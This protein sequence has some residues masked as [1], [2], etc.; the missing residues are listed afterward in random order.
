MMTPDPQPH[1]TTDNDPPAAILRF[2]QQI[3]DAA[4]PGTAPELGYAARVLVP[5]LGCTRHTLLPFLTKTLS[6]PHLL[7]ILDTQMALQGR[8]IIEPYTL[9][10]P[11]AKGTIVDVQVCPRDI[12][13]PDDTQVIMATLHLSPA[14][15]KQQRAVTAERDRLRSLF[16]RLPAFVAL[17][18]PDHSL[19]YVNQA[20]RE[21]FGEPG[22]TPCYSIIKGKN[23]PCS[24][25]APFDTFDTGSLSICEW[26]SPTLGRCFRI[27]SY[28]FVDDDNAS[29]VLKLG[30]D[31]TQSKQ[32]Q[33]ALALS[34]ARYR[35]ITDNL[36]VGIAV[37]GEDMQMTAANPL[38]AEW[39]GVP[40][41]FGPPDETAL[42]QFRNL[43]RNARRG[44]EHDDTENP[45]DNDP[46]TPARKTFADGKVHE[47]EYS[48]RLDGTER[49]FRITACPI[50][51]ASDK[52]GSVILLLEDVTERKRVMERL[53]RARRLEAMGTLAAG[54]AHEINQPLSALRL[55]TSGLELM[56]EQQHPVSRQTLLDRLAWILREADTI[57]EIIAHMRSLVLQEDAPPIGNASL[58]KAVERALSLVGAQLEAHGIRLDLHL[59]PNLPDAIAN[60][61]QLEQV[62]INLVVNAMHALDSIEASSPAARCIRIETRTENDTSVQLVVADNGPGLHGLETRI[63]D[64]FFTT[65]EAG[66]GMG[67]GL[68]IV[69]AFVESW[70]GEISAHSS[71]TGTEQR[72]AGSTG[73][74]F[75]ISLRRADS[76]TGDA[77]AHS[78][79]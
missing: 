14:D 41:S 18:A 31:I 1:A 48:C 75:I 67:L 26:Q 62:V 5:L 54:I 77:D 6:S 34:E 66:S 7:Q 78:D 46:L 64:P 49:T 13:L 47:Q 4:E 28:P 9:P 68:S 71:G 37:I 58:N 38:F 72:D 69:H 56:V 3:S 16:D 21:L 53:N 36:S 61:V 32:I 15:I 51:G 19:R 65:K 17:T 45:P 12:L 20:F 43:F 22:N 30:M 33:E 50:R 40:L 60:L 79:C 76:T 59:A 35:S 74:T 29:L 25:C 2:L 42:Q 44:T 10:L 24:V 39:F 11:S 57:Q 63:F 55:Y 27:Y 52:A 73:A 8:G 70:K 23:T